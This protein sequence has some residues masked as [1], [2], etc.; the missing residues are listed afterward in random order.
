V[1]ESTADGYLRIV[2][3]NS[4]VINV[5]GQKVFPT[6]IESALLTIP[7]ITDCLV[8]G[9]KNLIVG[10]SVGADVVLARPMQRSEIMR[11]I[12][13]RCRDILEPY[14]IPTKINVLSKIEYGDRYKKIRRR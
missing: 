8:Y 11:I 2:G 6:E 1:V 9:E 12:R 4:D 5:G 13:K 10:Q 14:K 7:E 3:R